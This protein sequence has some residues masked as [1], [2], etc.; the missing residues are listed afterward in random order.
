MIIDC[1]DMQ[2]QRTSSRILTI[3][4]GGVSYSILLQA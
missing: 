4:A 1:H 2:G 3:P